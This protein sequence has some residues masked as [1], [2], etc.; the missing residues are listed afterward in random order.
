MPTRPTTAGRPVPTTLRRSAVAAA[1]SLACLAAAQA[2]AQAQA[3]D[4]AELETVTVTGSRI[5]RIEDETALPMQT[6]TREDILNSGVS[7]AAELMKSVTANTAPLTDG[8]SITDSTS[9]QRGFNGA[10]LRGL[11]VSSTLVLLNGRRMANFAS[12]GDN[13][14]VDL[15]NIPA[16][17]IERIEVLKDGASAIYGT[18][19]IGGVINFI[20]RTDYEG[21]DLNASVSTTDQG[22]AGKTTAT[23]SAG[24]GNLADDRFNVFGVLDYQQLD[25]SACRR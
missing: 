1:V 18:D 2:E 3:Q 13:A 9:G 4:A 24:Y 25:A 10:N 19:A 23:V 15:N 17:A 6:I 8:V 21:V 16:G 14:G 7:T 11:G 20:T 12:P 22:G 5:K